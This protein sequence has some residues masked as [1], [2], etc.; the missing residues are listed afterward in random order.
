VFE[1]GCFVECGDAGLFK[2]RLRGSGHALVDA[3]AFVWLPMLVA[4][5][6]LLLEKFPFLLAH[7][8]EIDRLLGFLG[9]ALLLFFI[10]LAV[11]CGSSSVFHPLFFLFVGLLF[12]FRGLETGFVTLASS[13]DLALVLSAFCLQLREIGDRSRS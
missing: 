12:L 3:L 6:R 5:F 4:S 7:R 1:V 2:N 10:H 8:H 9:E 13:L 11:G